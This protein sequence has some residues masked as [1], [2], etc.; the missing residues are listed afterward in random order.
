MKFNKAL[1]NIFGE[2]TSTC[3]FSFKSFNIE[4]LLHTYISVLITS[5]GFDIAVKNVQT[6][7]TYI[8]TTRPL[9]TNI[10]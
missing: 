7:N 9:S 2:H 10:N 6:W 1:S 3:S 8:D 5:T 4:Y